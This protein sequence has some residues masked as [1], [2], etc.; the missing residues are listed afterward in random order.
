MKEAH[1]LMAAMKRLIE[2]EE[3]VSED[4]FEAGMLLSGHPNIQFSTFM[5]LAGHTH[6][7]NATRLA[8]EFAAL[9]AKYGRSA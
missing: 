7:H 4:Y 6:E 3:G 5:Y 1:D 9:E 8:A 2:L